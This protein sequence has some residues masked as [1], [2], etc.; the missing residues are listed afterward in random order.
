MIAAF[1]RLTTGAVYTRI[2]QAARAAL[3]AIGMSVPLLDQERQ[4]RYQA[5]RGGE[6]T[7]RTT[8]R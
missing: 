8:I 2:G 5:L 7:S 3:P 4:E 6:E 1:R